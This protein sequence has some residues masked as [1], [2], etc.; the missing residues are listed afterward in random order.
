IVIRKI[1]LPLRDPHIARTCKILALERIA[2]HVVEF[3]SRTEE[4]PAGIQNVQG[5]HCQAGRCRAL[6]I[7]HLKRVPTGLGDGRKWSAPVGTYL[8][9]RTRIGQAEVLF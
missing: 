5:G 7:N 9:R 2:S 1:V 8:Y 4:Y 6:E 3:Q